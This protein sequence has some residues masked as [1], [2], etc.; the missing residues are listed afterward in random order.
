MRFSTFKSNL[1][2]QPDTFFTG[3][4]SGRFDFQVEEDGSIF[5]DRDPFVFRHIINFLRGHRLNFTI[6]SAAEKEALMDDADFYQISALSELFSLHSSIV[7]L[8]Q[9]KIFQCWI[10]NFGAPSSWQLRYQATKDGF[11]SVNFH[12]KCD[13]SGP[14]LTLIKTNA[15]HIFGGFTSVSWNSTGNYYKDSSA[16][17]FTIVNPHNL[18]PTKYPIS[19][20]S[21]VYC[22]SSYGPTFGGG[23]DICIAN[24]ANMNNSSYTS[25]PSSFLDTTG[26]G[27]TTFTSNN[28]TVTEIEVFLLQS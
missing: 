6:L 9:A 14:S 12:S 11:A 19:N 2:S 7:N 21:A 24:N 22:G 23:H 28:F 20:S 17:L 25:F 1:L 13:N 15:G 16:F 10:E 8:E 5:I 4:L 27:N 3:M 18:P 26:K